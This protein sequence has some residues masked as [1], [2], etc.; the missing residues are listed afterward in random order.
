MKSAILMYGSTDKNKDM[1]Y[2]T[3][4]YTSFPVVLAIINDYKYMIVNKMEYTEAKRDAQVNEVLVFDDFLSPKNYLESEKKK[5]STPSRLGYAS[6]VIYSFFKDRGVG[7]VFVQADFPFRMAQFLKWSGVAVKVDESTP[8]IKQRLVKTEEELRCIKQCIAATEDV[9]GKVA[10]ML[11]NA[12]VHR[13]VLHNAATPISSEFLRKFI[14]LR[15]YENDFIANHPIV[16][17]GFDT[18]SPHK[19]GSGPIK[20][21]QPILVDVFP[22]SLKTGYFADLTR[23]F[24]RGKPSADVKKLHTAV[25]EAQDKIFSMIKEDVKVSSLYAAAIDVFKSY[26]FNTDE[27]RNFGFI[28]SLGHGIGLDVHE[29][30]NLSENDAVL[31]A[32]NVITVE[33]GLYYPTI[34]GVRVE[35]VVLVRHNSC[36]VLSGFPRDLEL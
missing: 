4:Y 19:E 17:C 35:D 18:A 6:E 7:Q 22:R 24:V 14:R 36:E 33:P 13:D 16:S 9:L 25:L 5:G 27:E 1:F 20:C 10:H 28:H 2:S 15:L 30:P 26:G 8:F 32:G 12:E 21:D 3:R 34:G 11:R 31:R 29:P 23:T